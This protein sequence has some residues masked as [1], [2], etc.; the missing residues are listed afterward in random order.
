[1]PH[2]PA[3][4][5]PRPVPGSTW[6]ALSMEDH[7]LLTNLVERVE[8]A[9]RA[10]VRTTAQEVAQY[11][12]DPL[13]MRAVGAVGPDGSLHAFGIVRAASLDDGYVRATCSGGVEAESRFE[14][15]G[16]AL[17]EWQVATARDLIAQTSPSGRGIIV[18]HLDDESSGLVDILQATGFEA[19]RWYTQMRRDLSEP[20]DDIDLPNHIS[21]QR[22]DTELHDQ[23]R[24]AHYRAFGETSE[25]GWMRDLTTWGEGNDFFVPEWS[26]VALDKSTDR[27][28]VAGY[29][30]SSRYEQ[31]WEALGW[32]EGYTEVMGVL[33]EWR[34]IH[35]GSALMV[36]AMRAYRDDGMEYA[37]LDVD[38]DSQQPAL[39]L[40]EQ[41]GYEPTQ[42]SALYVMDV[43]EPAP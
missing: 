23:V 22:W 24:Q 17:V 16:S 27:S 40:Y 21:I 14:G 31:D 38:T 19:R 13:D 39:Q 12:L 11:F 4:Q 41:L 28:R 20:I 2:Q 34:G 26:F 3:S 10:S 25:E 43:G 32:T 30:V 6:R 36:R 7:S 37:G 33:G 15:I 5:L 1:M 29:L 42:R 35:I 18:T 9:D 8:E